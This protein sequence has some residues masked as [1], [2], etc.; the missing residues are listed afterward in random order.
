LPELVI[1]GERWLG[2]GLVSVYS[3]IEE[4]IESAQ[5]S[6]LIAVYQ[7]TSKELI[8]LIENALNRG[9]RVE[10]YTTKISER[11]KNHPDLKIH[12]LNDIML[13]AK[14]II[15]DGRKILLGSSNFTFSGFFKNYEIG[16]YME[17]ERMAFE[18]TKLVRV[19]TE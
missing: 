13:H 5:Y 9:V 15:V 10:I 12:I 11:L 18:V 1:S 8:S 14:I 2:K 19:M 16:I 3:R 6:I 7:F 17:D 4:I